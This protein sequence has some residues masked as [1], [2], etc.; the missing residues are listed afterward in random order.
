MPPKSACRRQTS[1]TR[2]VLASPFS[3]TLA[4]GIPFTPASPQ[5]SA[6]PRGSPSNVE[7]HPEQPQEGKKMLFKL[8]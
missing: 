2:P 8:S 1:T 5:T 4:Q 6:Q 7:N 3:V